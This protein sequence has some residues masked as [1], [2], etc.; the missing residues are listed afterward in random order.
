MKSIEE[1]F[2][3]IEVKVKFFYE[4]LIW[5]EQVRVP[6]TSQADS[7]HFIIKVFVRETS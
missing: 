3:T 5:D 7:I 6:L 1:N 4:K 2:M